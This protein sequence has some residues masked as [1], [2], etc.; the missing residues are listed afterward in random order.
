[1]RIIIN[2]ANYFI[3]IKLYLQNVNIGTTQLNRALYERKVSLYKSLKLTHFPPNDTRSNQ[4]VTR[5]LKFNDSLETIFMLFEYKIRFGYNFPNIS[6][7]ADGGTET[8]SRNRNT[9][10]LYYIRIKSGGALNLWSRV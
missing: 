9:T 3:Q 10:S 2:Q 8:Q 1:M 6:Y 7:E 4:N 5:K